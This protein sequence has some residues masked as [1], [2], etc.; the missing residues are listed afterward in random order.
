LTKPRPSRETGDLTLCQGTAD[1]DLGK[2]GT[3]RKANG[4][5]FSPRNCYGKESHLHTRGGR[6]IARE[7]LREQKTRC[8]RVKSTGVQ[9]GRKGKV[10]LRRGGE[11]DMDKETCARGT[12][13]Q[14]KNL[15]SFRIGMEDPAHWKVT[16]GDL[17][18]EHA[19]GGRGNPKEMRKPKGDLGPIDCALGPG[20]NTAMG[21]LFS[22]GAS[23]KAKKSRV[24]VKVIAAVQRGHH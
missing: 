23:K 19:K 5:A 6:A 3:M 20:K 1:N 11:R 4:P 24:T 17:E 21:E 9:K 14:K 8:L 7:T 2:G 15:G 10:L 16:P 13:K 22:I 12:E 18:T